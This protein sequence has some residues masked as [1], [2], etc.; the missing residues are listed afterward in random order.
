MHIHTH[1]A[2]VISCVC[3]CLSV[4]FCISVLSSSKVCVHCSG[5]GAVYLLSTE[6]S[7]YCNATVV[8]EN[9]Y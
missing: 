1:P 9:I 5:D 6:L 2:L 7:S 8:I 3:V 4:Y